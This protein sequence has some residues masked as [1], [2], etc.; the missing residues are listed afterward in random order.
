M[1]ENNLDTTHSILYVRPKTSLEQDD[2]LQ[3]AKT[4]DPYIEE[5]G[6]SPV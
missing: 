2:F 3:I 4:V 6:I 5:S 1:I